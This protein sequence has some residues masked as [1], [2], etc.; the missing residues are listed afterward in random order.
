M[1]LL[2]TSLRGDEGVWNRPS[3]VSS[4][5]GHRV[6]GLDHVPGGLHG[7][8]TFYSPTSS[9]SP[10]PTGPS[11]TPQVRRRADG[12]KGKTGMGSDRDSKDVVK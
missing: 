1:S 10:S 2:P 6:T 4:K 3:T 11:W 12:C 5:G 9:K 7:P 8:L